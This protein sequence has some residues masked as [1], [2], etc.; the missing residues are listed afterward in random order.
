[1][2]PADHVF[3]RESGV[4]VAA[5]AE[6]LSEGLQG[7]SCGFDVESQCARYAL[8]PWHHGVTKANE[9]TISDDDDPPRPRN[10]YLHS[11]DES[12]TITLE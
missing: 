10:S 6:M 8:L 3:Q 11:I 5:Y 12:A 2:I 7:H 9:E 1:M 4:F